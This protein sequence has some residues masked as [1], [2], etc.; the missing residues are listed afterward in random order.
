MFSRVGIVCLIFTS[1]NGRS[2]T[3]QN[4]G[5]DGIIWHL[6]CTFHISIG[7]CVWRHVTSTPYLRGSELPNHPL[8]MATPSPKGFGNVLDSRA[9]E[10]WLNCARPS[11]GKIPVCPLRVFP[12]AHFYALQKNIFIFNSLELSSNVLISLYKM[13]IKILVMGW[14]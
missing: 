13:N 8:L 6:F 3:L 4:N 14:E 10:Q 7:L 2:S 5:D 12:E 1:T 9:P 11:K